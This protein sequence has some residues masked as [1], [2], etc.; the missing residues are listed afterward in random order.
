MKISARKMFAGL[1][2]PMLVL[3]TSA[4]LAQQPAPK[5]GAATTTQPATNKDVRAR[6]TETAIDAS[7]PDDPPVDKMLAVYSP[8]VRELNVML[9]RSKGELRKG[10]AG[11]GSLGNFV[12]DG[13]RSQAAAKAGKPVALALMNAG[14]IRRA[15]IGEGDL[16]ARDIFELL[17]FENALVVL[18]LTGEQLMKLL[19]TVVT[20]R[21]AQSGA[22]ITYK[23]NADQKSELVSAKLREA[24]G[25]KE[26]DPKGTY[27]IVT[28]DYLYRVGGATYGVLREGKNMKELG[29]T[30]RDAIMNYVKAETAAGRDIK[31]NLDGRFVFDR[32]GSA[33]PEE[34][35][36]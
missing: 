21:E 29:I 33:V 26:I 10:G 34:V 2:L 7:I 6:V 36:P 27:T 25:E 15:T 9:G 18:D 31:P 16:K 24:T 30:L 3:M 35:R 19:Q 4:A 11:A 28:I 14:G 32:A 12:T 23:T 17:P 13:M 1:S 8:K 5:T 20:A 22:R